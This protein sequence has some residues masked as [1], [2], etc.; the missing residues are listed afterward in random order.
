MP[1][2]NGQKLQVV[3]DVHQ[4]DVSAEEEQMLRDDLDGLTRQ[5]IHFPVADLHV[6]IEG[7]RRSNDVSVKLSLIL[8]GTT[9]VTM[10]HDVV[11]SAAFHRC[12]DSLLHDLRAYKERLGE[13]PERRK[14]EDGT[15]QE[16]HATI[17]LDDAALESA[18]INGDVTAF[19]TVTFPLEDGVRRR[20]GRWVQRYPEFE[21]RIG[22]GLSLDDVVEEVFLLAFDRFAQRP[23]DVPFGTWLEDLIDPAIKALQNHADRE[24]EDI[25][26]V[27]TA[28]AAEGTA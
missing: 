25:N 28:R 8:P 3:F 1:S 11:L 2:T 9:L 23:H 14:A 16:V 26:R 7:N 27:R 4:F 24:L 15:Y 12:R 22:K 18:V 17:A 20:I 21:A 10:D 19:R 6:L 5:V 13:V